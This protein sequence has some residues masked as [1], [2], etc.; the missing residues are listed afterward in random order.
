MSSKTEGRAQ[1][2]LRSFCWKIVRRMRKS[3]T[4]PTKQGL[5]TVDCADRYIAKSLYCRREYEQDLMQLVTTHLRAT[6]LIPQKGKG[7]FLDVGANM[8][9]T[10]VGM[11]HG[12]EFERA[13]AVEPDPRNVELLRRNMQQNGFE[14]RS[15][16]V[17]CAVSDR[18]GAIQLE[19]SDTNF[20]DHRVRAAGSAD[21]NG[22]RFG[23]SRRRVIEVETKRLDDLMAS[24]PR[25]FSESLALI[26]MDVQ[27]FEGHVIAGGPKIF[28][29]G[30]PLAT[31][32]WPYGILRSGMTKDRFCD[33]VRATWS[34]YWMARGAKRSKHFVRYPIACFDT[35]FDELGFEGAYDNVILTR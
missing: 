11:L 35:V 20:G 4:I 26:W 14:A 3:V 19:L 10:C 5:L 27:G 8:G 29:S 2:K 1:Y 15:V 13:V 17:H 31:E 23:E 24:L 34:H 21:S 9:V 16:C 12:G 28:T 22:E 30:I 7:T 18:A 33:I 6:G 25:E 32:I